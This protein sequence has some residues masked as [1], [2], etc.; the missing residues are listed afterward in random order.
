MTRYPVF[1][2]RGNGFTLIELVMTVAIV[3]ILALALLPLTQLAVQR[4]KETELRAA[5]RDIRT[6]ID[7]YKMAADRK[8]IATAVD[9]SGYPPSLGVLA[10]GV[11]DMTSPDERMIYFIR[12]IPR[13][14]FFEDDSVPAAQT[15]GLRSYRSPPD[16]PAEGEDVFDVYSLSEG[17]G[18]NG[19]PYRE[20]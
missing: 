1:A 4:A 10:E 3:A 14:P 17:I 15:W 5:L 8:R 13:D 20:W 7:E 18:L 11:R 19:V 9:E 12:R 16:D 2:H 6:A